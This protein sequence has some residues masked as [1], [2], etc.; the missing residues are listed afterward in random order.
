MLQ[1][2]LAAATGEGM[3]DLPLTD[4]KYIRLPYSEI[5]LDNIS[6]LGEEAP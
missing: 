4:G 1:L 2:A 5:T 3:E 6:R